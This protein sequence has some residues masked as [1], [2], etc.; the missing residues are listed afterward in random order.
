MSSVMKREM[1]NKYGYGVII[2]LSRKGRP[3]IVLMLLKCVFSV[4]VSVL[5][6]SNELFCLLK[7]IVLIGEIIASHLNKENKPAL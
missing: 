3:C 7:N 5:P 1:L 2:E 4:L 6:S